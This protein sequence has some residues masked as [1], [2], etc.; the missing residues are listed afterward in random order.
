ML[1]ACLAAVTVLL[2]ASG[3]A[4][5]QLVK[6][7][8]AA[9]AFA[10]KIVLPDATSAVAGAVSAPPKDSV[11]FGTSY[12][13][14]SDGS[15][16]RSGPVTASASTSLSES[17][18]AVAS[19][20]VNALSLFGGE[21]TVAKITARARALASATG[22]LGET[23]GSRVS[24]LALS[25]Q[26]V[27]LTPGAQVPL[28]DW[29]YAVILD[30][31]GAPG[32]KVG[33]RSY[34]ASAT[35]LMI[36]LTSDHVGLPSGSQILVGFADAS[37][38]R[39][40]P[41]P[42]PPPGSAPTSPPPPAA[43]SP[44]PPVAS[45]PPP[46]RPRTAGRATRPRARRIGPPPEPERPLFGVPPVRKP[47]PSQTPAL[48]GGD[49]VFPVYGASSYADTFGA[50]RASTSWH[51]GEDVFAQLGTPVLAVADGIVFSVG[52]NDIGG[53][54]LWL[55]D[56]RGNQFY[57]AH[58]S[59]FSPLAMN[60][61][62]VNAG[63][64]LG[65]VGSSGDAVGTPYHLHFEIHPVS[66]I[67]RGYDG[68][69]NPNHYFPGWR[70]VENLNFPGGTFT[71]LSARAWASVGATSR[72]PKPGAILLQLSD[73]SSA[74]GLDARTVRAIL[75][76]RAHAEGDGSFVA[77]GGPVGARAS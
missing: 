56:R 38:E 3:G 14:P 69:V 62:R 73:I 52:W 43:A 11:A 37:A 50:P 42:Q 25:G 77:R 76:D 41:P 12:V 23:T 27:P 46:A 53:N 63:D 65:F 36:Q 47:P 33:T 48:G 72:A 61:A 5:S 74:A 34:R 39:S 29:G 35:A 21:V 24:G 17:S 31:R 64:V 58:L 51:H 15:V 66:L 54:R 40:P 2:A 45:P 30:R 26:L 1:S 6:A 20:E 71:G 8:A 4:S 70:Q 10:I 60:G 57:Y 32:A 22:S 28:A 9:Q 49:Y 67:G 13:Y 16:V 7:S 44:P 19:S 59:G 68:A 55:R 75:A 18:R